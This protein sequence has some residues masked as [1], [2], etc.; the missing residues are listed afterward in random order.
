[1][2]LRFYPLFI[3]LLFCTLHIQAQSSTSTLPEWVAMIDNPSTNYF[4]AI[5]AFDDYWK[6]KI[7]PVDE[8]EPKEEKEQESRE[9]ERAHKQLRKQLKKMTP[10][11]RQVYDQIQY[12]YKR[13]VT[14]AEESKAY[15]QEDGRILSHQERI[16]IWNQQQAEGKQQKK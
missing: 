1:M 8:A 4:V 2:K 16:Q 7:R 12:H 9:E 13:F 5:K 14:W 10:A 11:E 3:G 15:V 6:D